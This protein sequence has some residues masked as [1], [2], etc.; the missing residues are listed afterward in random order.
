MDELTENLAKLNMIR[1]KFDQNKDGG[2]NNNN[3][4]SMK[5]TGPSKFSVRLSR[6]SSSNH[7]SFSVVPPKPKHKSKKVSGQ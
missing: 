7:I 1:S 5:K 2:S 3:S 6:G 4:N